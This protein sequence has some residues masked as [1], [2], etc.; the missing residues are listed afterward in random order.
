MTTFNPSIDAE[1]VA[2]ESE[3][4]DVTAPPCV[5]TA[6]DLPDQYTMARQ[7][8]ISFTQKEADQINQTL[9]LIKACTNKSISPN[10]LIKHAALQKARRVLN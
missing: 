7:Q 3:V 2:L 5:P 1:Q 9:D 6:E 8:H 4:P 10:K